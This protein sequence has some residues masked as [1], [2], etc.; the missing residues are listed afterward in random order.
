MPFIP[1]TSDPNLIGWW[2]LDEDEGTIALDSSGRG[3][4]GTL[5]G[6]PQWV[7]GYDGGGLQCDGSGDWATT[8]LLPADY[9][10]NGG[11]PKT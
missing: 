5:V 8:G 11:N 7:D 6:D 4:Y 1:L 9:G 2:K 10:L 3:N